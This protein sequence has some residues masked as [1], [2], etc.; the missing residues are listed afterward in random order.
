MFSE[1]KMAETDWN[2]ELEASAD[3]D[4]EVNYEGIWLNSIL[5]IYGGICADYELI[6]HIE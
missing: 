2:D 3:V 4:V 5:N 1:V 6:F